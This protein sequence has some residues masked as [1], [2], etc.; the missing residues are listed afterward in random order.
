VHILFV[1]PNLP[2][3]TSSARVR[4]HN[5][6]KQL[7]V[8][9]QV[10]LLSF[11]QS[12]ERAMLEQLRPF[13]QGLRLVPLDDFR[14]LGKWQNR[15]RGWSLLLFGSRPRALYTFP[16]HVMRQP[17]RD[18]LQ[19]W[20]P[21]VIHF[22]QLYLAELGIDVAPMPA[23]LGEQNVEFQVLRNLGQ[24]SSDPI[25]KIRDELSWRK[26]RAFEARMVQSFPVCLAVS[27]TDARH[28]RQLSGSTEVH[29]VE[30]GVDSQAFDPAQSSLERRPD[31]VLFF[32]TLNYGP[33]RD[34]IQ[35]FCR[36]VWPEVRKAR[37]EASLEIVGIDPPRDVMAL[38]DIPGVRVTGFV[39][40]IR[41]KL[42]TATLSI[43]P[44]RWGGGTRLKI[45]EAL[46]AGC[47]VVSTT[48]GAEGLQ[49]EDGKEIAIA[50]TADA[51]AQE[52]TDL[53]EH[54]GRR[55]ELASAG[56]RKVSQRYDWRS[57]AGELEKAYARAIDLVASGAFVS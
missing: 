57:I 46:A 19:R 38:A 32:G 6:I 56:Q 21:D 35:W 9:H 24:V 34:G 5:L 26:M 25:R 54:P 27:E 28:L 40:D 4:P 36:E 42:W 37:S 55:R 17:L 1:T 52:V 16:V 18:V 30:N 48:A 13:C 51:F 2:V 12:S 33:N 14:E 8:R 29:V 45:L 50:D 31:N 7:A 41:A 10:S 22:E 43:A 3:P 44:L 15:V 11:M 23:V 53:L 39:P 20:G 49:L 47:P